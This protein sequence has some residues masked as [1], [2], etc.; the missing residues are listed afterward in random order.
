MTLFATHLGH[1]LH[2]QQLYSSQVYQN[3]KKSF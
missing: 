3:L 1:F 2:V